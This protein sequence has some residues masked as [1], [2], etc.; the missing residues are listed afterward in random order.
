MIIREINAKTILTK[1]G[2]TD[3]C[4]NAYMGCSFGC[5]YCYAQLIIRKFHPGQVWGSYLDIKTNAPELL[6]KEIKKA[7]RGTVMLSSVTDPYQPMEKKY[8]LTK[9]CLEILLQHDFPITILTRSPLVTRDIELLKKFREC[10]VGVSITTNDDKMAETI[11]MLRDHGSSKKYHHDLIGCE[12]HASS[13]AKI[14][15][16]TGV[17]GAAAGSRLVVESPSGEILIPLVEGIC[18]NVDVPRKQIVVE[19]PEGLLEL[20]VTRPQRF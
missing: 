6:E 17:E 19:P 3:Y 16:V 10:T 11:R 14:G 13:G 18:V 5:S 4:I 7:K 2:I 12:V 20:N 9:K 8:E 15:R 1:S